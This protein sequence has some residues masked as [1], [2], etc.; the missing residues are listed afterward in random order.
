[1]RPSEDPIRVV[2]YAG[3]R[4]LNEKNVRIVQ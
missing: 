3:R 1:V 2:E 4:A